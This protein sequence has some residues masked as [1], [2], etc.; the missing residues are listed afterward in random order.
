E[1]LRGAD[2]AVVTTEWD[3]VRAIS[4]RTFLDTL[5]HPIVIDA[6]NAFDPDVMLDVGLRYHAMGRRSIGDRTRG[7]TAK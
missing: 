3:E 4:P 7:A 2:A 1:A 6:R 5:A